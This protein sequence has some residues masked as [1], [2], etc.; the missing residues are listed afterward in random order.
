MH[1]NE[2]A[3]LADPLGFKLGSGLDGRV[4][5]TGLV[6]VEINGQIVAR[7]PSGEVPQAATERVE[8]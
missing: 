7:V 5:M 8:P 2:A 6:V 4:G 1:L 3:A